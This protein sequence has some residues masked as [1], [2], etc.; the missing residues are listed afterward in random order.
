MISSFP[1]ASSPPVPQVV[2]NN[3]NSCPLVWGFCFFGGGGA[4]GMQWESHHVAC[5]IL[6]PQPGIEPVSPAL[7]A[8]SL[9]HWTAREVPVAVLC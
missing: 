3:I 8:L 2:R 4:G 6:V 9:N 7:E 5:G 1:M